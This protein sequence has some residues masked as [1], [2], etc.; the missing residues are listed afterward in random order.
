M[1]IKNVNLFQRNCKL[2]NR[3]SIKMELETYLVRLF[4]GQTASG[5]DDDDGV[6]RLR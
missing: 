5:D 2:R 3:L 6:E 4:P 1:E